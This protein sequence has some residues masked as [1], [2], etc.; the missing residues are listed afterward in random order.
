LIFTGQG[1]PV[2]PPL[3]RA[4][5]G[6]P[7]SKDA[8]FL[9]YAAWA[10]KAG[11]KA[12]TAGYQKWK[13]RYFREVLGVELVAPGSASSSVQVSSSTSWGIDQAA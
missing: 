7:F 3:S 13:E 11:K 2:R 6:R 8:P 12:T 1:P 4:R 9:D 5:P 10:K